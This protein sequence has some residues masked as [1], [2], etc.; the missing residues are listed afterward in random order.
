VVDVYV[1][2]PTLTITGGNTDLP[3]TPTI[4]G[5]AFNVF[6]GDNNHTSTLAR[7]VR[8]SDSVEVYSDTL[9]AVEEFT[10]PSGILEVSKEYDF[11]MAYVDSVFGTGAYGTVRGTTAATFNI[12]SGV[13]WNPSSDTYTRTGEGTTS[14]AHIAVASQMKRCVLQGNGVV[15]YY[16]DPNDSTKKADGTAADLS[17]ATGNVMVEIPKF[18]YKYEWTGTAHHW[19]IAIAPA[20]GYVVH[21]AFIKAGVEVD[22]RYTNAYTP[23]DNGTKLISASG[24]YP[25]ANITRAGFRTKAAANGTGWSLKTYNVMNAI[26]LLYLVEYADFNA[27][28]AI[29]YGRT[30]MT[31]GSWADGSYYALAGL[32]NVN[33]NNTANVWVSATAYANNYMSYRGIEHWYGHLFEWIDGVNINERQWYVNDD[34]ATFADDVF[35]GNYVS[36]GT[37]GSTDGYISNFVQTD[38]GFLPNEV[39]GNDTTFVGDYYTQNTG[40]RVLLVGGNATNS[41]SAGPWYLLASNAASSVPV[42]LAA[43]LSY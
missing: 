31:G 1:E 11:E 43:G 29:G 2:Q 9:G 37:A 40:A 24:I 22:Y 3:E 42:H 30:Y 23:R 4:V 16:L 25:T 12:I 21:P 38:K 17:G 26:N 5:S 33:G 39:A 15:A 7:V 41:G 28:E 34:P 10:V 18:Y 35:S 20:A 6:N 8:V 27:Q 19:S 14:D 13:E 32:S 36:I